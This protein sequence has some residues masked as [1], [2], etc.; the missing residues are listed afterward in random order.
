MAKGEEI[1]KSEPLIMK[2]IVSM[3]NDNNW[4][5]RRDAAKYLNEFLK[6]LHKIKVVSAKPSPKSELKK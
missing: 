1:L 5:I 4:K 3:C 6:E 2:I